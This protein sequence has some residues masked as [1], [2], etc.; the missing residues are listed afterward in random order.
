MLQQKMCVEKYISR[1]LKG[2]KQRA[3]PLERER[4]LGCGNVTYL[5]RICSEQKEPGKT[6]CKH[7]LWNAGLLQRL[8][9]L[10][11]GAGGGGIDEERRGGD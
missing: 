2:R 6:G 8:T 9:E 10:L 4:C 7:R 1:K 3:L 5:F 11:P